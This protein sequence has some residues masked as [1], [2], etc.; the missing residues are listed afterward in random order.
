MPTRER[1]EKREEKE[2]VRV[3]LLHAALALG[4]THGFASL[5]LREVARAADIAPTSFYRHFADMLELGAALVDELVEPVLDELAACVTPGDRTASARALSAA[6]LALAEREPALLRFVIA[7]RVGAF[8][9]LRKALADR[10]E[11]LARTLAADRARADTSLALLLDGFARALDAA[12]AER[13]GVGERLSQALAS[14]L[15]VRSP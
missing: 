9:P 6:V 10:F 4:A 1:P 15:E 13:A 3:S 2:R 11:Q 14:T 12:P 8:L 7:E 5:G